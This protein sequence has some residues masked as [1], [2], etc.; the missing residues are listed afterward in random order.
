[1]AARAREEYDNR[2]YDHLAWFFGTDESSIP[3]WTGYSLGFQLLG[4]YLH[5]YSA[6]RASALATTPSAALRPTD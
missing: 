5:R 6:A 4:D 3:R 2:R 1:M